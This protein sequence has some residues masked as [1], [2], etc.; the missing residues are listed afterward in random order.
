MLI[1]DRCHLARN[2]CVLSSEEDSNTTPVLKVFVHALLD[3][4]NKA[5][6]LLFRLLSQEP[7]LI[8]LTLYLSIC[9][10]VSV[11]TVTHTQ[12]AY[13]GFLYVLFEAYLVVFTDAH[14]FPPGIAG[15][16]F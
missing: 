10:R 9:M 16:V 12:F 6:A 8:A 3:V 13:D 5:L 11:L 1:H 2:L 4:A 14:H 7:M 15:L